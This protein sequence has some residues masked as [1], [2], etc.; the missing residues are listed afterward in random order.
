[1]KR[2]ILSSQPWSW[3]RAQRGPSSP[4]S[5][6]RPMPPA[7]CRRPAPCSRSTTSPHAGEPVAEP[8]QPGPQ[9]R[10]AALIPRCRP[11]T[12]I[13][14]RS[15]GLLQQAQRLAFESGGAAGIQRQLHHLA[16]SLPGRLVAS[17]CPLA[18]LLVG[19]SASPASAVRRGPRSA[20]RGPADPGPARRQP[21]RRRGA[22]GDQAGNQLL[23]L[24]NSNSPA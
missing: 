24:Q 21:R 22:A 19:L 10:S 15:T 14:R 18:E 17:Q 11:C 9:S 5:I 8:G 1:M 3:P 4:C 7:S 6:R 20:G 16:D 12:P 23:A 2:L 13:C